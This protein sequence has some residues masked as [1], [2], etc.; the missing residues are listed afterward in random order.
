MLFHYLF[1][2]VL[3]DATERANP[4][5]GYVLES[6]ARS[7]ASVRVADSGVIHPLAN[8]AIVLL[9]VMVE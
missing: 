3:A 9:H 4:V 6:C 1:K 7:D 8:Y 5:V 2:L